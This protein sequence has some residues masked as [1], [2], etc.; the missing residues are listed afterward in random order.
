MLSLVITMEFFIQKENIAIVNKML[1]STLQTI[2]EK[3]IIM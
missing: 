2:T 3:K 1:Y